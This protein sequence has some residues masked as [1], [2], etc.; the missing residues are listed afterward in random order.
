[1]F[2]GFR[3]FILRGNVVDLAVAVLIGAAFGAITSALTQDII[4]PFISAVV[5]TPDF[6]N[7]KF[8]MHVFHQGASAAAAIAPAC[9][10]R[11]LLRHLPER[12][13][14]LPDRRRS[15]VLSDRPSHP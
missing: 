13:D 15:R 11:H 14:Q 4:T 6:S 2:K 1:M 7:L 9:A 3:D 8:H 5:G 12:G 10:G